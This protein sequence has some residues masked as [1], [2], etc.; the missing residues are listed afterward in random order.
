LAIVG[1]GISSRSD[2]SGK[3]M[4]ILQKSNCYV[5]SA[6]LLMASSPAAAAAYAVVDRW[7]LAGTKNRPAFGLNDSAAAATCSNPTTAIVTL[8]NAGNA[9]WPAT[10]IPFQLD[11]YPGAT[12]HP[13]AVLSISKRC[14]RRVD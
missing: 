7:A 13:V 14:D 11:R 9:K 6:R 8:V 12:F 2:D 1:G 10:T 5:A 4:R 3:Q